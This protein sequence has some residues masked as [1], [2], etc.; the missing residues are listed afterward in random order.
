MNWCAEAVSSTTM[1]ISRGPN[2]EDG[3]TFSSYAARVL[4][5][6][7]AQVTACRRTSVVYGCIGRTSVVW[8]RFTW[9]SGTSANAAQQFSHSAG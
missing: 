8:Y 1:L 7:H 6:Q 2:G 5:P 9:E 4:C 3:I